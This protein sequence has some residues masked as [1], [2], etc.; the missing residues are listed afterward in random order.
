M[1]LSTEEDE[2]VSLHILGEGSAAS[3]PLWGGG[4]V[5]WGAHALV[6]DYFLSAKK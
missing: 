5:G 3:S 4:G 1:G 6:V 2:E